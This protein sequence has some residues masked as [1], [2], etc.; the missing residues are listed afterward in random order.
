MSTDRAAS[1]LM[2]TPNEPNAT[3]AKSAATHPQQ[4]SLSQNDDTGRKELA[5]VSLETIVKSKTESLENDPAQQSSQHLFTAGYFKIESPRYG[6]HNSWPN[7]IM[8]ARGE[9]VVKEDGLQFEHNPDVEQDQPCSP[10][11]FLLR[12]RWVQMLK[13]ALLCLLL[14]LLY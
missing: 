10:N 8:V 13:I 12:F 1:L 7:H 3:A 4:V 5:T 14:C 9:Y 6:P 11:D 2:G